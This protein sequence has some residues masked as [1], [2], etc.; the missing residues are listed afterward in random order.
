MMLLPALVIAGA[1]S[2]FVGTQYGG[3]AGAQTYYPIRWPFWDGGYVHMTPDE[4]SCTN[5]PGENDPY[6]LVT[7]YYANGGGTQHYISKQVWCINFDGGR[8]YDGSNNQYWNS[9]WGYLPYKNGWV[10]EV[11]FEGGGNEQAAIPINYDLIPSWN[12]SN[13]NRDGARSQ[14][15]GVVN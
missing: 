10:N 14:G 7:D 5:K 1:V 6:C 8:I 12:I 13:A 15:C 3:H 4:K 2:V 9:W 11:H